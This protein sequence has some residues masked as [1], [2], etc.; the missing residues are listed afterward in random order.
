MPVLHA[1]AL[2][3]TWSAS[4]VGVVYAAAT[5]DD[6]GLWANVAVNGAAVGA[7]G[8]VAKRFADGSL[9][10][11][12]IAE[13]LAND[14]RREQTLLRSIDALATLVHEAEKREDV[15]RELL[16][17]RHRNGDP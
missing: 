13:V 4:F 1:V 6:A 2:A 17:A 3:A 12:P 11:Q 5:G 15:I 7:L 14:A 9:V 16:I 10:A 8:Y